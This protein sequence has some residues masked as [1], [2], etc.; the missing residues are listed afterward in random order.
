MAV[1]GSVLLPARVGVPGFRRFDPTFAPTMPQTGGEGP[2]GG[3]CSGRARRPD[4][5][6]TAR[7]NFRLRGL[8]VAVQRGGSREL[9]MHGRQALGP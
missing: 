9:G 3:F 4:R 6:S 1:I 2:Q 8:H 7:N 5:R